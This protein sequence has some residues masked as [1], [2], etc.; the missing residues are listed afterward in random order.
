MFRKLFEADLYGE[1]GGEATIVPPTVAELVTKRTAKLT[2]AKAPLASGEWVGGVDCSAESGGGGSGGDD[3]DTS[4]SADDDDSDS[5]SHSDSDSDSDSSDEDD[6]SSGEDSSSD[7]DEDEEEKH[8]LLRVG[9]ELQFSA[10]VLFKMESGLQRLRNISSES[11]AASG[12][13]VRQDIARVLVPSVLGLLESIQFKDEKTDP[14]GCLEALFRNRSFKRRICELQSPEL[15]NLCLIS[16]QKQ[17]LD[18][19]K[20]AWN[21]AK[22]ERDSA[23]ATLV[24]SIAVHALQEYFTTSGSVVKQGSRVFVRTKDETNRKI[25]TKKGTVLRM[26][27]GEEAVTVRL[28]PSGR[29]KIVFRTFPYFFRTSFPLKIADPPWPP[30]IHPCR[31]LGC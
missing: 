10:D 14:G 25:W 20:A 11:V 15:L 21:Q 7:E 16:D 23:H 5:D 26:R 9:E 27:G 8:L 30:Q 19:L 13:H 6:S 1:A 29:S 24:L 2:A 31:M 17:M 4:S 12:T 18:T 28:D 22:R 3:D